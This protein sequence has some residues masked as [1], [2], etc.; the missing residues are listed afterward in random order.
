L[1]RSTG[2]V[3][4][5][6]ALLAAAV[7]VVVL[8]ATKP[9]SSDSEASGGDAGVDSK[10]LTTVTGV[11]GSEKSEFFADPAVQAEF[12][13][14][15]LSVQVTTAGSREIA[16]TVKLDGY[17]FAF[18]SSSAAAQKL[19]VATGKS[20]SY[21]P[22]Y[23]PMALATWKPVLEQLAKIGVAA[24]DSAG[25]WSVDVAKYLEVVR[26]GTRWSDI[27][28][29][30]AY[31][32]KRSILI[33]STDINTSNSAAMYMD[34]ASYVLNEDNVVSTAAA[35]KQVLPELAQLFVKQ[36][37][38]ASSS[39]EPFSDYLSQGM[40]A[41]PLVNIYEAQFVQSLVD[42]EGKGGTPMPAD[43]T[44]A[45]LSP[46]VF[47]KHVVVPLT[48]KG[49]QVGKLLSTDKELARL[50]AEHGF[51]TNGSEFAG[52]VEDKKLSGIQASIVN[53]AETPSYDTNEHLIDAIAR[54]YGH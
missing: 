23:S 24:Q 5:G 51:R 29:N 36:G 20:T 9:W 10:S 16:T 33:G 26:K 6:I 35:E 13:K 44:L 32:S 45:Y 27:P 11:I 49:D 19:Q 31:P 2:T 8:L 18:P 12:A 34:I 3:I 37:F 54:Q 43:A 39:A 42:A 38:T 41:R 17:D 46:T 21:S 30:T 47:S 50:A 25:V 4:G 15:G 52:V 14:H 53:I 28:G 22:F 48:A 7:L 1:N 40:G